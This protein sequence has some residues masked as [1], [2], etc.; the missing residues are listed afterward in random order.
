MYSGWRA[1]GRGVYNVSETQSYRVVPRIRT[2]R[3][4][5]VSVA[6]QEALMDFLD[7]RVPGPAEQDAFRKHTVPDNLGKEGNIAHINEIN[8][9]RYLREVAWPLP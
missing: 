9:D 3:R 2:S 5:S 8:N 4:P 1:V 7:R 6:F